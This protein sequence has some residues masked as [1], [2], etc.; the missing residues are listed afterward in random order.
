M[1]ENLQEVHDPIIF[2]SIE[3]ED[4]DE[5][6]VSVAEGIDDDTAIDLLQQAID[7]L[8]SKA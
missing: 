5:F 7:V 8:K 1:E 3:G 6:V 4:R 2:I